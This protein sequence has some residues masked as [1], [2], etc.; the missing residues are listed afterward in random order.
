[1]TNPY[2]DYFNYDEKEEEDVEEPDQEIDLS[3]KRVLIVDDNPDILN[4]L[5]AMLS[6]HV[7]VEVNTNP[8]EALAK[9][10]AWKPHLMIVD[11]MMP[12]LPGNK[13]VET[14]QTKPALKNVPII[15]ISAKNTDTAKKMVS[16][17]NVQEFI[18][19]PFEP[20]EVLEAVKKHL[21][22]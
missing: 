19:K 9:A 4:I 6:M 22:S 2:A 11:W 10:I 12:R 5:H 14:V 16:K 18:P 17:F 3:E 21:K 8:L 13:F 1:M 7:K 15:F 20:E